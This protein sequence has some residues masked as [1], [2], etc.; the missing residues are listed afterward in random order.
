MLTSPMK[1]GQGAGLTEGARL[2]KIGKP[3]ECHS[4]RI[5]VMAKLDS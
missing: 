1:A 3:A 5:E 4:H 2:T